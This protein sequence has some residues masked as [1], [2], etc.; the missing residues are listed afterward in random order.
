[1]KTFPQLAAKRRVN[2]ISLLQIQKRLNCSYHWLWMLEQGQY[3]GPAILKW[4]TKY[5]DVLEELILERKEQL[6][7]CR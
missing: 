4:K 7:L 5:V 1:M 3:R 6:E 2:K